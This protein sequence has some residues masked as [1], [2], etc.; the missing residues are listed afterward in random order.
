LINGSE[1]LRDAPAGNWVDR[2]AP[3]TLKPYLRLARIDRPIG[4][5]L[6]LLPCWWSAALAAAMQGRAFPVWWH[7][8]LFLLG[9]VVMRGAGCVYN[10]IVDRDLDRQV[11]R[12]RLRPLPSGAV[13]LKAAVVLL[14][15]LLTAGLLILVQFSWFTVGVG[16][17]SLVPI[18]IYPF[19]KRITSFPQVVLGF[20]FSWGALMG[21][22]AALGALPVA[23]F[24]LYAAAI[25]WTFGYDTIYAMQ[26][27]DDD[28]IAGIRS[29]ARFFGEKARLAVGA[30]YLLA[31]IFLAFVLRLSGSG[32]F[33]WLGVAGFAM[34]LAWQ[35]MR[36]ERD[37]KARALQVF[38]S[39]RE[40]GLILFAGLL[41]EAWWQA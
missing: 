9:A 14:I 20:A 23:S 1:R 3:E 33:A 19:M 21:Y 26:D 7:L 25:A 34:H 40:A 12:T 18:L 2:F 10:D 36:M 27:A 24:M 5:W 22:A 39:N 13:S 28:T 16:L 31:L 37:N 6:L 11:E 30:A 35:V 38:R 15:G 17:G 8:A 29:T 4:W 32:G 41:A